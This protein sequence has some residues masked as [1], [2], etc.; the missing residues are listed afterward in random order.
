LVHG[1]LWGGNGGAVAEAQPVI[2]DPAVHFA[3]RLLAE[4]GV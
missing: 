2:Y 3:D 4:L 1:D